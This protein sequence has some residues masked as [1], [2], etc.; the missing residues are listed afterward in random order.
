MKGWEESIDAAITHLL[1]TVLSRNTKDTTINP[2]P[3]SLPADTTKV[4]KH[5]TTFCDKLGKGARLIR[6]INGM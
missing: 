3:F 5:I 1:R 2:V 6:S 4:C